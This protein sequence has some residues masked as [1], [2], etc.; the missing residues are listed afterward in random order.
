M[1]VLAMLALVFAVCSCGS[2]PQNTIAHIDYVNN[3]YCGYAN[4]SI[5]AIHEHVSSEFINWGE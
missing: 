1:K 4:C 2:I 3:S 5:T